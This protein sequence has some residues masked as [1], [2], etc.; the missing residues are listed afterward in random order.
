VA[1]ARI[2]EDLDQQG[3]R[4]PYAIAGF[5]GWIDAGSASSGAI[6]HLVKSLNAQRV[7]ELEPEQFY[8]FSDTRPWTRPLPDQGREHVWPRAELFVARLPDAPRDLILFS[9]PEPNLRWRTFTETLVGLM[10]QLGAVG[11]LSL[12]AVLAP[13]HYRVRVRLRGWGTTPEFRARLRERRIGWTSYE[14]PTGIATVLH[15]IAQEHGLPGAGLTALTPSYLPRVM[16]PWTAAALLRAAGDL[17]GVPLP[18]Q[19][20]DDAARAL[21]EQIDR[22]LAERPSLREEIEGLGD[23]D[24]EETTQAEAAQEPEPATGELPTPEAFLQDMEDFLRS[25]RRGQDDQP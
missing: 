8:A 12:G 17:A 11:L 2:L 13:V 23:P 25:L 9:A 22:F 5:G 4:E 16:H 24:L 21:G 14:G 18:L 3:L 7:A 15:A 20:L 10:Q 1:A 6:E 19:S